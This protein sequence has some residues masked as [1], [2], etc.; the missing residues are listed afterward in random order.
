MVLLVV[1]A[2]VY[3]APFVWMIATSLKTIPQ[4]IAYPPVWF[5]DPINW[6]TF[7]D[8]F[9]KMNYP[10]AFR[11]TLIYAVPA[12]HRH[13]PLVQPGR[14]RVRAGPVARPERRL[15]DPPRRR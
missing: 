12:G 13:D 10:L 7:R 8:A 2:A 4:S 14:V 6:K 9:T 1:L 15:P 11:N 5:P 3:L